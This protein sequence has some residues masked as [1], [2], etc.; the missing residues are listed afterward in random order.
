MTNKFLL[1]RTLRNLSLISLTTLALSSCEKTENTPAQPYDDGVF[2][3]NEGNFSSNNGTVSLI[4]RDSK[5]ATV[6]VF[7]KENGKS[8][9]GGVAGYG[10]V[11]D[12]GLILVDNSTA[13]KDLV[14]VVNARTFKSIATIKTDIENP[15]DVAKVGTNKAYITCFGTNAD[16]K[17]KT[18]YVAVV[19]LVSNTVTKK[20]PITNACETIIVVGNFAY[21]GSVYDG[22]TFVTILDIQKDE[23][24]ST[25][26]VGK[27]PGYFSLDADNKIWMTAGPDLVLFNPISKSIETTIKAG[28]DATK[29]PSNLTISADKKTLFYSY[30]RTV[31]SLDI[32]SKTQ[33]TII[34][35]SFSSVG[36]DQKSGQVYASI[37]PSYVQAGYVFRYQTSGTL[38]DS[39]KAEIAPSGFYF[40]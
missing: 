26:Q 34:S 12:K 19:D 5:T 25:A 13:G 24:S 37:I 21:L 18:S 30:N 22:S 2:V 17:Y 16:Y 6:D 33:K 40:K 35:R 9:A 31:V 23:V 32:A 8:L 14:E 20:I 10:E 27:N 36:F 15:R 28:S 3:I 4:S 29:N 7:M 1:T 38:I 11:D 39:V